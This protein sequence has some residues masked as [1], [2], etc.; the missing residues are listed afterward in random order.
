MYTHTP[1]TH[2]HHL[3]IRSN[4]SFESS[5]VE[6][7]VLY[8]ANLLLRQLRITIMS[9][10]CNKAKLYYVTE[11]S[12]LVAPHT[13]DLTFNSSIDSTFYYGCG[14]FSGLNQFSHLSF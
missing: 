5:C 4:L 3:K 2:T 7:I 14:I 8:H 12:S 9:L 10:L 1:Y 13:I 6:T 11:A